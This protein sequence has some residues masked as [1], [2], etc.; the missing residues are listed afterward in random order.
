MVLPGRTPDPA[1]S[2]GPGATQNTSPPGSAS[3]SNSRKEDQLPWVKGLKGRWCVLGVG[4]GAGTGELPRVPS[5]CA[6][7]PGSCLPVLELWVLT[8][9][10]RVNKKAHL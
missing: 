9:Q 10:E 6:R 3:A 2:P 5:V 8:K 7:E 1:Q 4:W